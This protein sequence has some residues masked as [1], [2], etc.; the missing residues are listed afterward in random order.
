MTNQ[1]C[2]GKKE[3]GVFLPIAN[4]GWIVSK[5]TPLLDGSYQQNKQAAVLADEIGMDFI[6]S[7]AKWRGYGGET[8]HWGCSMESVSMMCGIAE[9]TKNAKI[10]AT[11][12]TLLMN[13]GAV[14]KMIT[15]LDQISQG[16]AGLNIV[17]GSFR[18]ELN[19]MGA[20][21]DDVDHDERYNYAQ[22]WSSLVHRL[23]TEDTVDFAGKYFNFTDCVSEPKPSQKP[24]T[25]CAGQSERGLRFSVRNADACFVGGKDDEETL[26]ITRLARKIADEYNESIKCY[27]M[28]TV[29]I[30]DTD[31]KAEATAQYYRDGKDL[32]AVEGMMRS[33]GIDPALK[34]NAMVIRSQGAFMARDIIG[35]PETVTQKLIELIDNTEMDGVMINFDDYQQGLTLFG[36][37]VLPNLRAHYG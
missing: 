12:H 27:T 28:A 7:M 14:A 20:W 37:H 3:F 9:A 30:D 11:V 34:D 31:E 16:R 13:P 10:I 15:T 35:S 29:V 5:N 24:F 6:M 22:E 23:W 1:T 26:G 32:G 19:Q 4:G 18:D 25:V 33:Y 36:E 2:T 17:S 21:R 8:N